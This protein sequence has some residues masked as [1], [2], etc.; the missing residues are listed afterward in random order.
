MTPEIRQRPRPV[1]QSI[2][3]TR[4]DGQ[5]L[6]DPV[7][8]RL[9]LAALQMNVA[10]QVERIEIAP[11]GVENIAIQPLSLVEIARLMGVETILQPG[12]GHAGRPIAASLTAKLCGGSPLCRRSHM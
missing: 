5:R 3:R 10:K 9:P 12:I 2:N 11:V 7:F 1:E 6:A 8:G 4:I